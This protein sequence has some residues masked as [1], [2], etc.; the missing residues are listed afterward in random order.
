MAEG[1]E[2]SKH[3]FKLQEKTPRT[4]KL[5]GKYQFVDGKCTIECS[6]A[7]AK[8]H[9]HLLGKYYNAKRVRP[10]AKK[11]AAENE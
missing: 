2:V 8:K 1:S 4:V 3:T 9:A 6:A 7:D 5:M 10:A 11:S